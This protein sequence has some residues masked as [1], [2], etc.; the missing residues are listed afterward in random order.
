MGDGRKT[1]ENFAHNSRDDENDDCVCD[2][3][4]DVYGD[5]AKHM[6]GCR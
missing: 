1:L 3:E 2:D 5:D 6:R 4:N